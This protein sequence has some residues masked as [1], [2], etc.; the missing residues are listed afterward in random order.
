MTEPVVWT[1][2]LN[3]NGGDETIGCLR[4]LQSST[5]QTHILVVDNGSTDGSTERIAAEFPAVELLKLGT[6]KGFS[7]GVN[8]GIERA[9]AGGAAYVLLLNN[10]AAVAPDML[11]VLVSYAEAQPACGLASP[12]IYQREQPERFWV[13]G[14]TWRVYSVEH[15]GWN[16]PDTGQYSAPVAFDVVFGTALLIKRAVFEVIGLF[17]ERFFVYYEDVDFG[18]R[19]RRAG[20]LAAVVPAASVWHGG[21]VSTR[22]VPYLKAYYLAYCQVLL[23][24]KYLP[25]VHFLVFWLNQLRADR[26]MVWQLLRGGDLL[27][28]LAYIWGSLSALVARPA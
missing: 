25:G 15:Q 10:D 5:Y 18:L 2:V 17:D 14:G 9:L 26:R 23:F 13:V 1:I 6:N 20:F 3:W 12:L 22:S 16:L 28:A 7:G 19:A 4:S 8:R 11:E 21:S 24:R 27:S